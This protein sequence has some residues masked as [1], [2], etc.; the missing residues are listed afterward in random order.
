M[1]IDVPVSDEAVITETTVYPTIESMFAEC[2][3]KQSW[4]ADYSP[5]TRR[6]IRYAFYTGIAETL[7]TIAYRMNMDQNDAVFDEFGRDL[8]AFDDELRNQLRAYTDTLRQ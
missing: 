1:A 7:R 4:F 5:E 6:T 2:I 8:A 3:A